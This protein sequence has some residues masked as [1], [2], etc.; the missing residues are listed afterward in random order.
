M[1][2]DV[3]VGFN[4]VVDVNGAV[5]FL[6]VG[7]PAAVVM[8]FLVVALVFE[9]TADERLVGFLLAVPC[10]SSPVSPSPS[11]SSALDAAANFDPRDRDEC[12]RAIW[13]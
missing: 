4:V 10:S 6:V 9:V 7:L 2:L 11:L 13:S 1:V 12:R 5:D 3:V 8:D